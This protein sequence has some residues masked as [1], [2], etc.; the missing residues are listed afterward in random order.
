MGLEESLRDAEKTPF[1]NTIFLR[2]MLGTFLI[3]SLCHHK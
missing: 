3:F 2:E 1:C